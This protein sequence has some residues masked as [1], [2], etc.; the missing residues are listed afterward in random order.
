[1]RGSAFNIVFCFNFPVAGGD[2]FFGGEKGAVIWS[3][4]GGEIHLKKR[5]LFLICT[6]TERE[7]GGGSNKIWSWLIG[8]WRGGCFPVA[9]ALYVLVALA[10]QSS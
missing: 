2:D 4:E 3:G 6:P 1:M 9:P 5:C 10:E 7:R 8:L